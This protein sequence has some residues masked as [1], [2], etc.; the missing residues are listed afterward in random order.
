MREITEISELRSIQLN[1]L[2][3]IDVFCKQNSIKYFLSG[4]TMIGAVRHH[5]YIP[6]DDDIDIMMLRDDYER[7]ISLYTQKDSSK[8][9]LR[10]Y[11]HDQSFTF[12]FVKI[13]DSDTLVVENVINKVNDM[14]IN[15]DLFPIDVVPNDKHFQRKMYSRTSF[16][17]NLL[18]LKSVVPTKERSWYKNAILYFSRILLWAIPMRAL[19]RKLDKNAIKYD[20]RE[21]CIM[22]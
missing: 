12:P 6:W 16:I 14:G 10:Y 20:V 3:H 22:G 5:G 18:A 11:K 15:V 9:R 17:L 7:F 4:G 1:I 8:Y 13:D 21:T 2:K 19:V